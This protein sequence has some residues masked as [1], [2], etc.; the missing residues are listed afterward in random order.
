MVRS[1][2]DSGAGPSILDYEFVKNQQWDSYM[3]STENVDKKTFRGFQGGIA[4][5][6]EG[7]LTLNVMIGSRTCRATFFVF[8]HVTDEL[9]ILGQNLTSKFPFD[10]QWEGQE[11]SLVLPQNA[12]LGPRLSSGGLGT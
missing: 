10:Y 1:L 12:H 5:E 11:K 4:A 9:C 6:A 7:C 8:K 3:T 2:Y